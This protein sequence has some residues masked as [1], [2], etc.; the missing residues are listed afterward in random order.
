MRPR[1][2]TTI[3]A[4]PYAPISRASNG[5]TFGL[6]YALVSMALI[7]GGC[8]NHA[9]T[10]LE[11]S[12][13][14]FAGAPSIPS[15]GQ[16]QSGGSLAERLKA[17]QSGQADKVPK[18]PLPNWK[19]FPSGA[20]APTIP[21][22][23]GLVEAI[24]HSGSDGDYEVIL[25]TL[26]VSSTA[27]RMSYSADRPAKKGL[28]ALGAPQEGNA[29]A[30]NPMSEFPSGIRIVDVADLEKAHALVDYFGYS[31][32][33][34]F[35]GTTA[36]GLSTEMLSQ[37]RAGNQAEFHLAS[38]P[39]AP[40]L[41]LGA[42]V[43][44]EKIDRPTVAP[45]AGLPMYTCNLHRVEPTD[46]AFPV[47]LN[48]QRVELRAL[49]AMCS[50]AGNSN[51]EVHLYIL[52]EPSYPLGLWGPEGQVIKI[53]LPPPGEE[54]APSAAEGGGGG[55]QMEQALAAK[56]PVEVYGIY[57]DFDSATIRPESEVVLQQI[58]GIL[59]KNPD[60]KLNVSGHTDNIG[61]DAFN[62]GLSERRAAAVKDALVT[63]YKIAPDRLATHGY[64]ASR[65][66]ES[67][68]TMEGRARNR[69]VELQR[70]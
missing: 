32:V 33:E 59:R 56:K 17:V 25:S 4:N 70:Q 46:F 26:D 38:D 55:R 40:F 36:D 34:H 41:Q 42:Q 31:P 9:P 6:C 21:L 65:P 53:T 37:L 63:R 24:A 20:V 15:G 19:P 69:R 60:W 50:M 10:T 2:S 11:S 66:I 35:P 43:L 14:S 61:G 44:G 3:A 22:E 16:G 58:A 18:K 47:L 23:K 29:N 68:D 39:Y 54:K 57:F 48:D 45:Y 62:M 52:D 12:A 64:G 51:D 49:H 13:T 30:S 28:A 1:N 67:N 7:A 5:W 27:I 8:K